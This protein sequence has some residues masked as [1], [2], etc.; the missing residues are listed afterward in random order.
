VALDPVVAAL[1]GVSI[2]QQ[3]FYRADFYPGANITLAG[4]F[5]T[6]TVGFTAVQSIAPGNGVYLTSRQQSAGMNYSYTGIRKWN[7]GL[8]AGFYKLASIGQGIQNYEAFNGGVG[9]TYG[10]TRALH[11]IARADSR[12]QEIMVVGYNRTGYRVALGLGFSPGNVPLSL[13]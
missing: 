13:W 11:I 5:K 10:L 6:S 12:Y 1:F 9:I 3:T 4:R 7:F 2:G 8:N